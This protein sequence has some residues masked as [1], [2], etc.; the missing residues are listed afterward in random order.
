M[1]SLSTGGHPFFIT[2]TAATVHLAL[3]KGPLK[4]ENADAESRVKIRQAWWKQMLNETFL[5]VLPKIKG[6]AFFEFIKHEEES[7]RDFTS[8]GNGGSMQ[9]DFGSDSDMDGPTLSAFKQDL[10]GGIENMIRW[11]NVSNIRESPPWYLNVYLYIGIVC[12]L[13]L[14][15]T[16]IWKK[17][18][19]QTS[20]NKVNTEE[21]PIPL[22][23]ATYKN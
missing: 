23:R 11:A 15:G 16:L 2:E 5:A 3:S 9:S 7:W 4:L 22:E 17:K 13:L 12:G 14:L 1:V 18:M 21:T 6:F 20:Q 8:L 19:F 10:N